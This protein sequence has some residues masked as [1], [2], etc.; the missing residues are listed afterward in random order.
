MPAQDPAPEPG[1]AGGTTLFF[2]AGDGARLAYCLDG[3]EDGLPVLCLAG[4]TR[5]KEDFI[6]ALPALAGCRVIRM[7]YRG[8][9]ESAYTG[10]ASYTLAQE[11]ADALALLDHLAISRAALLGTSRGGL[12]GMVLAEEVP[13]RLLG[14]CLNDIGPEIAPGGL[15]GIVARLG[16]APEARSLAEVALQMA[17]NS[18]GFTGLSSADWLVFAA[19]L[20]REVP[21]GL[22][23]RY[24]P[25]LREAFLADFDPAGPLPDLWPA[26][27]ASRGLPVA[28]IRGANSDLLSPATVARMR[29][30]RPDLVVAEVAGRGHV[31]FLDEVD[32]VAALTAWRATILGAMT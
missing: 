22:A 8:R 24:D 4:L 20:F 15:E 31:P 17:A 25:A 1:S 11:G 19:R 27:E 26:W 28:L 21:G 6:P 29:Q 23:L 9:G 2:T 14:L 16:R 3:P 7:D 18:P 12:I 5:T 13:G 10:A 30:I 32:S